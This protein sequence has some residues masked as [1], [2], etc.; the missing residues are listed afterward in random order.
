M[1]RFLVNTSSIC[2]HTTIPVCLVSYYPVSRLPDRIGRV[3][4]DGVADAVAW[5]CEFLYWRSYTVVDI[6]DVAS[7]A[8]LHLV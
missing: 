3:I 7:Q 1:G 8:I 5:S 4:I 6:E 2:K